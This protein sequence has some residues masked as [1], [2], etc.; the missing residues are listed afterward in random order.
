MCQ[1]QIPL[2]HCTVTRPHKHQKPC[3]VIFRNSRPMPASTT[4]RHS[5]NWN[6]YRTLNGPSNCAMSNDTEWPWRLFLLLQML[7]NCTF[8]KKL[9]SCR[10]WS[11]YRWL[12]NYSRATIRPILLGLY[13][14]FQSFSQSVCPSLRS[15]H[16]D[17]LSKQLTVKSR[18]FHGIIV[19]HYSFFT[20]NI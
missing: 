5:Y 8:S 4:Q 15:S 10:I 1:Q 17:T 11:A 6:A 19:Q 14:C 18:D 16:A 9:H 7:R 13:S 12:W 20:L 3:S 2:S